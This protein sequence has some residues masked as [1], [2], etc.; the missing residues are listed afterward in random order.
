MDPLVPW[1]LGATLDEARDDLRAA[2]EDVISLYLD[3]GRDIPEAATT[4]AAASQE[5]PGAGG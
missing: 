4:V 2:L 1:R 5:H 3:A